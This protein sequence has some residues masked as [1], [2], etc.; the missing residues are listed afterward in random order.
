MLF[1]IRFLLLCDTRLDLSLYNGLGFGHL[2]PIGNRLD[3]VGLE[4]FD[5]TPTVVSTGIWRLVT[6]W[7]RHLD[8]LLWGTF[9]LG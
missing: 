7:A 9:N 1:C 2:F 8:I 3:A 4:Q 6:N 5:Q